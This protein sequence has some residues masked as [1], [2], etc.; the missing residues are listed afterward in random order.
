VLCGWDDHAP[1]SRSLVLAGEGIGFPR[2]RFCVR[3][4]IGGSWLSFDGG[5]DEFISH[6]RGAVV[7]AIS[8]RVSS[9]GLAKRLVTTDHTEDVGESWKKV[10][11]TILQTPMM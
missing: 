5:E 10:L 7:I 2:G 1:E 3:A 4:A 8:S 6:G 11:P 9:V